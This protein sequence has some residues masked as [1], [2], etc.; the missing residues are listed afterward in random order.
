MNFE[1][2]L[3]GL[4]LAIMIIHGAL[5]DKLG[6]A[7]IHFPL[8]VGLFATVV[9]IFRR[10]WSALP[11]GISVV[12]FSL[13]VLMLLSGLTG[14]DPDNSSKVFKLYLK[15]LLLAVLIG[16][17]INNVDQIKTITLYC[18]AGIIYG[19][20]EAYR[21]HFT[22]EYDV[23]TVNI[24]RVAGLRGDPNDTAMLLLAG[25]PLTV[26]W[27]THAKTLY[28][29]LFFIACMISIIGAIVLTG[30]RGGFIALLLIMLI[31]FVK[32]PSFNVAAIGVFIFSIGVLVAPSSYWDRM[33]SLYKGS[34]RGS[35]L[36][37]RSEFVVNGLKIFSDN[38]LLGV[39]PGNFGQAND[40]VNTGVIIKKQ[41]QAH[42]AHN[43]YLQF[44]VE[45]GLFSGMFFLTIL[46]YP[47]LSLLRFD[48]SN[49]DEFSTYGL[50]FCMAVSLFAMLFAGLF[51]SQ[52]KNS[53][54]WFYIGL[55]LAASVI[56]RINRTNTINTS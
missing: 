5:V 30:S 7:F 39:G 12:I 56:S 48:K 14:I 31:I 15:G 9:I 52:A 38:P 27:F 36:K 35:S 1:V 45:N 3:L 46:Y 17:V 50:G 43:M 13:V 25:V 37:N 6:D 4:W 29:K 47:L 22:G 41:G 20:Y 21:Q 34:N 55:G 40:R 26:Y 2:H 42:A 32:K 24:Q 51:L 16:G 18:L 11:A 28:A 10:K 23:N 53:V 54:L 33:E 19:V 44:F 8:Y 49:K